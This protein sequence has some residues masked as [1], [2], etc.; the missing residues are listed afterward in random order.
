[1]ELKLTENQIN[2]L[3]NKLTGFYTSI[4]DIT[5]YYMKKKH[6]KLVQ[7]N[8]QQI[9]NHIFNR[10]DIPPSQLDI[11]VEEID[12]SSF[13]NFSQQISTF[14]IESQIGRQITLGVKD[15][16][17][18]TYLGFMRISS[19][20]SSIK[21]RNDM[22]G[23]TLRLDV[24]NRHFYNGQ[25]IVP[26]QPF[27]YNYLGGK[28]LSLILS[29]NE[30][31]DLYNQK[32]KCNVLVFETTSLY[33]NSKSSSQYDGLEPYIKYKGLTVSKNN[34]L[35]TDEVWIEV[36][37]VLRKYYGNKEWGN[38]LINPIPSS[39]KMREY[40][41]A[42]QILKTHLKQFNIDDYK[43]FEQI[44]KEK[45]ITFQQKR[46]Y[47]S[48]FGYTNVPD[49]IMNG[50]PLQRPNPEKYDLNNIINYWKNKSQKRWE[51][52]KNE[53][54]L[55]NQIEYY[56]LDNTINERNFEIIR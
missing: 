9:D 38:N 12:G 31:K 35:P 56:T 1:M 24:V 33:G 44:M 32:Y 23:T 25:T 42:V 14:P 49:H 55:H 30:I 43:L 53:E 10:I 27:G 47:T 52:L 20:V 4:E 11:S 5:D 18:N 50:Q 34:L 37:D 54:R 41:R 39:P 46:Y 17:T 40:T 7:K 19:P 22:F 45:S 3:T 16:T 48:T 28:L 21:P 8:Y 29:S 26:T 15:K 13:N 6:E 51:K 2:E 36:R